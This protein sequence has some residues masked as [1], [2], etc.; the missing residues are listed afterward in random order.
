MGRDDVESRRRFVRGLA[1]AAGAGLVGLRPAGAEAEPPPETTKLRINRSV[2][3][4]TAPQYV[5][6]ALLRAEG[7]ADVEYVSS[8]QG[9]PGTLA[10]GETHIGVTGV[11]NLVRSVDEGRPL[12]ILAGSHVGCYELFVTGHIR[13]V[14]D[15]K[16]KTI[17]INGLRLERHLVLSTVLAHVGLNPNRDVTWAE[18][19]AE[20]SVE[21]LAAG[22]IDALLAFPPEPQELRAKGIGRVIL[23]TTLDRPW[24]QYFCCMVTANRE[25]VR[26]QPVAA[27]RALRAILKA[28]SLCAAEPERVARTLVDNG[29]AKGYEYALHALK[30]IPYGRWREFDPEDAVRFFALRLRET[31]FIESTPQK[32]LAEGTDWRFVNE[33]KKELKG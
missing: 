17:A 27:K 11:A 23:N 18:H 19:P 30:E 31:G 29:F 12:V 32:I 5:A 22:K 1:L 25:F 6:E 16:G 3:I 9:T 21:L 14:R 26:K 7:F 24:S 20:R 2:N 4:C 8:E 15:L 13:T 28:G 10:T 33:L